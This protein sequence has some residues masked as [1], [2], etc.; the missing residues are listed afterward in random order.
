VVLLL[1][2]ISLLL[3]YVVSVPAGIKM[4]T[5]PDAFF[6]RNVSTV[7]NILFSLPVFWVALLLLLAFANPYTLNIFPSSGIGP[8]TGFSP[9]DGI[10]VKIMKTIP[11]FV[12]PVFCYSYGSFA[13]VSTTL[14]SGL[15]D[16]LRSDYI[17][18]ATAKGLDEKTVLRKHAYRNA[19]LP[20]ITLFSH[21][22]PAV[23]GGSII[24]ETIFSIPGMG[25]LIFQAISSKDIPVIIA[26]FFI[27]GIIT[28]T[29]FLIA[30]ILYAFA[31]PRIRFSKEVN[32]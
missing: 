22:F 16:V 2:F 15:K 8:V 28:M 17:R 31:D 23:I 9:E 29:G 14:A 20:L 7:F 26:V 18:T 6:V 5:K 24:I 11:Y 27:I 25:L 10:V 12:L 13:F 19:F 32:T 21:A 1:V 3:A 4:A 30:D